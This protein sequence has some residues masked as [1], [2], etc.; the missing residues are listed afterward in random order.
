MERRTWCGLFN[1]GKLCCR[2]M[3]FK[4][5]RYLADFCCDRAKREALFCNRF[6]NKKDR[7]F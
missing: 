5:R 2:T 3:G 4:V 6:R 1:G 7:F